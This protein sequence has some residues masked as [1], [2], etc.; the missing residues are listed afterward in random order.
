MFPCG[1]IILRTDERP[2]RQFRVAAAVVFFNDHDLGAGIMGRDGR[3]GSS[4]AIADD[5]DIGFMI[6]LWRHCSFC[7]KS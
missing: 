3:A 5:D 1:R 4:P 7:L 6:P 2:S